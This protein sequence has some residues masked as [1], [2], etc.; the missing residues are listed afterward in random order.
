MDY[1]DTSVIVAALTPERATARIQAWLA[2]QEAGQLVISGWVSTE[3][4]SAL[5]IK[6]RT[7]ALNLE[8]RADVLAAWHRLREASLLV[9][10]LSAAHFETAARFVERHDLGLRA[11]DALHLA[12]A[13]ASG[14]RLVTLDRQMAEAAPALGVPVMTP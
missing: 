6:I 9:E 13:S 10:T 7:G 2:E 12:V 1:L 3:V 11:G 5:S 4:S 8:Q 14:H